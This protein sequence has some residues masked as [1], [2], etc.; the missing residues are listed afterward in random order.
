M[1][2][3]QLV[4]LAYPLARTVSSQSPNRPD[5]RLR[6]ISVKSAASWAMW[7]MIGSCSL[8]CSR[9]FRSSSVRSLD[10]RMRIYDNARAV[11]V[12]SQKF[13]ET[14]SDSQDAPK[15]ICIAFSLMI[16]ASE[17]ICLAP[18]TLSLIYA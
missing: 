2:V 6:T 12:S 10:R 14:D 16:S 15:R 1:P 7:A 3:A 13:G 18:D 17:G 11:N 5:N 9:W 4:R 8:T